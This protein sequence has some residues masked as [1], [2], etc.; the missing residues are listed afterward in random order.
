VGVLAL[1]VPSA[2]TDVSLP[3]ARYSADPHRLIVGLVCLGFLALSAACGAA[4]RNAPVQSRPSPVARLADGSPGHIAVIV[5]ENEEYGSIIGSRSAPYIN[6]L[7]TRYALAKGMYAVS[8]PSLPN[9]LALTGG[10][11]FGISSDC[12]GC[13][14]HA[15]SLVDQLEGAGVSWGAYMEGL[16]GPCFT[17]ASAG[18][19]AKKHDPFVYFVGVAHAPRRCDR[20]VPFDRLAAS[21]RNGTLPR[22][23]WI[24]P[25]LC[26]DMHDCSVSTGDR[27]LSAV[28]PP[29]LQALGPQGLLF[30]TWDEGSSAS[31]CC[32]LAA[33]GHIVTIVAGPEARAGAVLSVPADHYSVLQTIEDLLGLPRLR[34]AACA[35]TPSLRP[36][37]AG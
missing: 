37:L 6:G 22:F 9:Y 36:L 28:V 16:P 2:L 10:S 31:G 14:V 19:Y 5:M 12:T 11:T 27:F 35:C 32:R 21:E 29:L 15:T 30:L 3:T 13:K 23:V 24:T 18:D 26:H 25:N 20:V 33:G 8:H 4:G 17:G 34:G 7:A 1:D